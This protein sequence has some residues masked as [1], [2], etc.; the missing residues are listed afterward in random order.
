MPLSFLSPEL[1]KT[2]F[3]PL[4]IRSHNPFLRGLWGGCH[5][6]DECLVPAASG[7]RSAVREETPGLILGPQP[8]VSSF[9]Q[10]SEQHMDGAQP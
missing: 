8:Q 3:S 10:P 7:G 1:Y 9:V 2:Q 6:S 5:D 4:K